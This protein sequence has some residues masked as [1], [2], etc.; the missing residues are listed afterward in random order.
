MT[1]QDIRLVNFTSRG[2]V[3]MPLLGIKTQCGKATVKGRRGAYHQALDLFVP[4]T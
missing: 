2:I 1:S 4:F 3:E